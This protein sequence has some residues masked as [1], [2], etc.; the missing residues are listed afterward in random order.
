MKTLKKISL[1]VVLLGLMCILLVGLGTTASAATSGKLKYEV[2][3]GEAIIT[4]FSP[5]AFTKPKDVE[6]PDTINDYP[7]T[8]IADEAFEDESITSVIIPDSVI[9]IGDYAFDECEKLASVTLGNSVESIGE[10]AFRNCND[11]TILTIPESVKSIGNCAFSECSDFTNIYWNAKNAEIGYDVF[12]NAGRN[13]TGIDVVF[14]NNVE[15]IPSYI[16]T[17][18][19][20]IKSITIGN[21]VKTIADYAFNCSVQNGSINIPESVTSIGN[22]ALSGFHSAVTINNP[23]CEIYNSE[24][25]L[26]YGATIYGCCGS[27][28]QKY[29]DNYK[30]TFVGIG[31]YYKSKVTEP[32]CTEKGYTTYICACGDSYVADYTSPA[33]I[34]NNSDMYCDLCGE[35]IIDIFEYSIDDNEVSITGFDSSIGGYVVIPETIEGYPVTS[36]RGMAFQMCFDVKTVI[37]PKSVTTIEGFAFALCPG[38]ERIAIFNKDCD[39]WDMS[40]VFASQTTIYGYEGSTAQE[41]AEKYDRTFINIKNSGIENPILQYLS[42]RIEY[43][44]VTITEF[45][46]DFSGDVVIPGKIDGYPVTAFDDWAFRDCSFISVTTSIVLL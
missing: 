32:I 9:T 39:I 6:I 33:H 46:K 11:I 1:A 20:N 45:D 26:G 25:T 28:A 4:G 12:A 44:E 7:V 17:A 15:K 31:H 19:S 36:I 14:G 24:G 38:I 27:T 43:G 8:A 37:I 41:Y 30:R 18:S 42:Y 34:N 5:T 3:D 10:S 13:G 35:M 21:S 22:C 29:A 23:E 2:S 16:F 40:D